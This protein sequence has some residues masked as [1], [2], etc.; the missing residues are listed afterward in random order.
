MEVMKQ[1]MKQSFQSTFGNW[2]SNPKITTY[3]QVFSGD[4]QQIFGKI[5]T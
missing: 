5:H 1:I 2:R 3:V 4:F